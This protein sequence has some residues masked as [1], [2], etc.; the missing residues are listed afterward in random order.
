[1]YNGR[2]LELVKKEIFAQTRVLYT[3]TDTDT[4]TDTCSI[5]VQSVL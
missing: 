4:D 5:N 3:D 1:M 2:Q